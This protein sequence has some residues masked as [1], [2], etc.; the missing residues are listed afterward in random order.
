MNEIGKKYD[1]QKPDYSLV[2]PYALDDVVKVLT[3]GANK[4]SA[5]NWAILPNAKS[6]YF[7][8]SMRH[9]WA[10]LRGEKTDP[11]TGISHLAHAACSIMFILELENKGLDP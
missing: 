5:N 7:A 6:R 11:E 2:P 8:A 3:Y 1:N 10:W 4:Y 9:L